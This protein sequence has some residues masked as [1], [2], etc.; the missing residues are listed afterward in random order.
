[1]RQD[2]HLGTQ[3]SSRLTSPDS[4]HPYYDTGTERDRSNFEVRTDRD[5]SG[6]S[7]RIDGDYSNLNAG[8]VPLS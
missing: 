2:M 5:R 6:H 8:R 4:H 3:R 1:M 7:K